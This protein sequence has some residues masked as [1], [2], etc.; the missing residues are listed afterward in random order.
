MIRYLSFF[1]FIISSGCSLFAPPKTPWH[2]SSAPWEKIRMARQGESIAPQDTLILLYSNR[3]FHP[4]RPK[5]FGDYIDSSETCRS[6]WIQSKKREWLI[7]PLHAVEDGL[8]Y[9]ENR[10][11]VVY[12]EGMGKNFVLATERALAVSNQY[13][14][15]V[16]LMDYPSIHPEL[17][18]HKNFQFS[19][20]NAY[21]TAPSFVNLLLAL[22]DYKRKQKEDTQA[23]YTLF[24]HSM[25]N[26]MLQRM[27]EDRLD[28]TLRS[29]LFDLVVLNAPCVPQK[30]HN[31]W[32]EKMTLGK[33]TLVHYNHQDK[34]LNGAM[35]LLGRKQ[36]GARP[37]FP[38]AQNAQYVDFHPL[39]GTLH[40]TF[41]DIPGRPPIHPHA[42]H[43]FYPLFHGEVPP[44]S[45]SSFLT[46]D[47][48][49]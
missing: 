39:V 36:L 27:V 2:F 23:R 45:D 25:G 49:G 22:Q 38:L 33:T 5:I 29:P 14:V 10:D 41:V 11:V 13:K 6:F 48:K 18:M 35:L 32:L 21:A 28:S 1:V 20:T 24:L 9:F 40:S 12:G 37:K 31:V 17:N 15:A 44:F 42:R 16:V 26:I 8:P 47:G 34:Q 4:N 19:R 30:H 3:T 46:R 7:F 43:Y